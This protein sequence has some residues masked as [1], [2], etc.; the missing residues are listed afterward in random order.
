LPSALP[1]CFSAVRSAGLSAA[2]NESPIELPSLSASELDLINLFPIFRAIGV[3]YRPNRPN[4]PSIPLSPCPA[5][6]EDPM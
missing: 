5:C 3:I 1:P 6:F 2:L 4:D